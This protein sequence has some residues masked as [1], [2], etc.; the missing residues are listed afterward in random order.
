MKVSEYEMPEGLFYTDGYAWV[1]QEG[2]LIRVGVIDFAVKLAGK[3]EYVDLP[4]KGEHFEEGEIFG[5]VES[6]KWVGEMIMPIAGEVVD[7][8]VPLLD[9]PSPVFDDPYGEG[10]LVIVKPDNISDLNSLMSTPE[11]IKTWL[12]KEIKATEKMKK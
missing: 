6:G 9:K 11:E 7:T 5:T 3:I 8:N 12:E 4:P 1:K 10:W 2:S